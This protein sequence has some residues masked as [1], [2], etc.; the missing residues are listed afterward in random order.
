MIPVFICEYRI[1]GNFP[2]I[3]WQA[4]HSCQATHTILRVFWVS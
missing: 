2:K 1:S 3:T 4:I